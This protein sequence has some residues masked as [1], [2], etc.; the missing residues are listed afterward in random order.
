MKNAIAKKNEMLINIVAPG[1]EMDAAARINHFHRISMQAGE[2]AIK[3]ALEVGMQLFQERVSRGGTFMSW[4]DQNCDFSYKTAQRYLSLLQQSIGS[5]ND[6]AQLAEMSSKKREGV[7]D[8]FASTVESKTL[9]ELMCDYGIITKSKSNLGG[10]REGAGRKPKAQEDLAAKAEEIANSG[11]LAKTVLMQ[12]LSDLYTK[13][14]VEGG[15][16]S[17]ETEDL[18]GI[19][20]TIE[21]TVKKAKEILK[22]RKQ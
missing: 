12:L 3:A 10:K 21:D 15:F 11:A 1:A 22:S 19:V 13:G 8:E 17:L 9:S 16:G 18:R 2:V 7:I 4:V 5:Q 6:L 20:T 14:V